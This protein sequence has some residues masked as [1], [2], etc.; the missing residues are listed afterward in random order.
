MS[1]DQLL[2]VIGALVLGLVV[3]YLLGS[4]GRSRTLSEFRGALT[5]LRDALGQV[6]RIDAVVGTS[7]VGIIGERVVADVLKGLPL[8]WLIRDHPVRGKKVEFAIRL[9]S[10]HIVPIDSKVVEAQKVA[11]LGQTQEPAKRSKLEKDIRDG[12]LDQ[13]KVVAAKYIDP[14]SP[15]Y[16]IVAIPDDAYNACDGP[17]V[18]KAFHDHRILVVPYSLAR[19]FVLV[20]HELDQRAAVDLDIEQTNRAV[21]DAGR[22]LDAA[23]VTLNGPGRMADAINRL[24]RGSGDL[25]GHLADAR[26][27]VAKIR[28]AE[29]ARISAKE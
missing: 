29:Q 18:Y 10:G 8:D 19:Q 7:K 22:H 13:A 21:A 9:P 26:Q 28:P 2:T 24:S 14:G 11:E 17:T 4:L 6:Q 20:L 5:V 12:V 27:A 15:G 3:G 16:A 25:A 23:I 1:T